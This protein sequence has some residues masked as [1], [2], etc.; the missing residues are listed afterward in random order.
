[1]YHWKSPLAGSWAAAVTA[2]SASASAATG[3]L[4]VSMRITDCLRKVSAPGGSRRLPRPQRQVRQNAGTVLESAGGE[5][6]QG[7]RYLLGA[8]LLTE[9]R[10]KR[11]RP[12]RGMRVQEV[13]RVVQRRCAQLLARSGRLSPRSSRSHPRLIYHRNARGA[14]QKTRSRGEIFRGSESG[15]LDRGRAVARSWRTR[16]A[17]GRDR[18]GCARRRSGS[19]RG[20][21]PAAPPGNRSR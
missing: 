7:R 13:G 17:P 10:G 3:M 14:N 16:R 8:V 5:G 11:P 20:P 12:S 19:A 1:M 6:E 4:R 15:D 2:P 9:P 18:P 21:G